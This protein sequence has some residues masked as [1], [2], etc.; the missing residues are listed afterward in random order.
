M[1]HVSRVQSSRIHI[2]LWP[3]LAVLAC[4]LA[5]AS[6]VAAPAAEVFF[7]LPGT[8]YETSVNVKRGREAG[9]AM[10]VLGGVH[11]DETAGWQA[12]ERIGALIAERDLIDGRDFHLDVDA[13]ENRA[14]QP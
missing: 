13:I 2:R 7:L 11:G 10:L 4:W 3:F 6:P 9:P 5:V 12:A 1:K 8:P 14:G